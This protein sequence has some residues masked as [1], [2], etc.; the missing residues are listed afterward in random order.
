MLRKLLNTINLQ[1]AKKSRINKTLKINR[2]TGSYP[3]LTVREST[4]YFHMYQ[5][6]ESFATASYV[7]EVVLEGMTVE[8]LVTTVQQ[9]GYSVDTADAERLGLM[10]ESALILMDTVGQPIDNGADIYA[11][12]SNWYRVL[13]PIHRVLTKFDGDVNR[14][15]EE[16]TLPSAR[17]EW[18]DY[19]VSFFRIKRL[20]DES[21]DLLLRRAML[22]LSN[23]KSNN[24]AMEELI[25]YYIATEAKVLDNA[26]SQIE[27]RVDPQFMN[28]ATKVRDIIV[29]LKSAGVDYFL[30]YQKGFEDSYPVFFRDRYGETFGTRNASY[31][32]VDV[33]LPV[34]TED[35]LFV[36]IELRKGFALNSNNLNGDRLLSRPDKR[37]IENLGMTLTDGATGAIIQQM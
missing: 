24:T 14:A 25:S 35:Y 22:T 4:L 20:P 2:G 34:Y 13:Y 31:D 17:G 11:F 16:L 36:P 26:P 18:L 8:E 3:F 9:M 29:L 12:T 37:V 1:W 21:D 10:E 5:Q 28:S 33:T 23:A 27:V 30:N 7:Q 6:V 19:W 15:I 32:T